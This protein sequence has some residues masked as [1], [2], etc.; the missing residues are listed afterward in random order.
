MKRRNKCPL[1]GSSAWGYFHSPRE[2]ETFFRCKACGLVYQRLV[3]SRS[4]Q[5]LWYNQAWRAP[6]EAVEQQNRNYAQKYLKPKVNGM[7][8][9]EIGSNSGAMLE[10][11][12]GFG[13]QVLGVEPAADLAALRPDLPVVVGFFETAPE[14]EGRLFDVIVSFHVLEHVEFPVRFAKLVRRRL[15][16]GGIWFNFMP[17]LDTWLEERDGVVKFRERWIHAETK[18]VGEHV[19]FFNAGTAQLLSRIAGFDM[20]KAGFQGDDLW[21]YAAV[22]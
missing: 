11:L 3:A 9:L 6:S 16:P 5:A 15:K 17:N 20:F 4:E 19:Q 21:F 10:E 7:Q 13:Y 1:C 14:L 18:H 2:G 8:L 12:R 22:N